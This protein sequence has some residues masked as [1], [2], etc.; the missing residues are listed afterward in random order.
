M[1]D[2]RTLLLL[3]ACACGGAITP[4]TPEA[5]WSSLY[6]TYLNGCANC[7]SPNGPGRTSDIETS[8]DFSSASTGYSTVTGSA[9]GLQGNFASC[10]GTRFV[11]AGHPEQSLLVA[12]LDS[13][14]RASFSSG[15]CTSDAITDETVKQGSAPPA[16]WMTA[17]Q[18]WITDGAANN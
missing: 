11:V 16:G 7:H 4:S 6:S 10:N 15:G 12:A 13:G 3:A 14:T 5:K 9:A 8:L 2:F 18:Q 17:L 1:R